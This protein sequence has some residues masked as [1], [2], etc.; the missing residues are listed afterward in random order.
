MKNK[1][2][3][4]FLL[5]CSLASAQNHTTGV[6][7]LT[8]GYTV[9]FDTNPTTV[10][11]T[12]VGSSSQWL[13]LGIGMTSMGMIGDGVIFSNGAANL[14]DRRFTGSLS[15][16]TSDA[17]QNWTTISNTVTLGERTIVATRSLTS[18]DTTGS[19]YNFTNGPSSLN[20]IWAFGND[21]TLAYHNQRGSGISSNFV[22]S[23]DSFV[24]A[25]FSLYPN[26]ADSI[27]AIDLP[28][29][30]ESVQVQIIDILG[31]VVVSKSITTLDNKINASEL[32]AG[33]YFIKVSS[34]D[35]SY[36][37]NLIIQ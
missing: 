22:L 2:L 16:P 11:M 3:F 7:T 36:T 8:T 14:T 18:S 1:I 23:S 30:Y 33:N 29:E 27:F 34:E 4:A 28:R 21:L 20:L 32:V 24:Q 25:G 37:T 10:T 9:K 19:D 31:K 12:L 15:Q 35:K 26:P 5:C 17:T 13:G 6:I